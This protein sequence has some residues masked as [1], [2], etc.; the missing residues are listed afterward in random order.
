M[1]R[2][3]GHSAWR[4]KFKIIDLIQQLITH[5]VNISA[6][7][8]T[9]GCLSFTLVLGCRTP[10][11][12]RPETQTSKQSIGQNAFDLICSR[13]AYSERVP[14]QDGRKDVSGT[15]I[16]QSC[17]LGDTTQLGPSATYLVS[18]RDPIVIAI[19]ETIPAGLLPQIQHTFSQLIRSNAAGSMSTIMNTT[20]NVIDIVVQDDPLLSLLRQWSGR[21]GYAGTQSIWS[22][23]TAVGSYPFFNRLLQATTDF[24][25]TSD[26][27]DATR[28][29]ALLLSL[30]N[31][32]NA[33]ST[34]AA[35]QKPLARRIVDELI[36]PIS[37]AAT[38][39]ANT[40]DGATDHN[41]AT[42]RDGRGIALPNPST[43]TVSGPFRDDNADGLVDIDSYGRILSDQ[44]TDSILP[45]PFTPSRS[46]NEESSFTRD[47]QGR[48]KFN[49]QSVYHYVDLNP[50]LLTSL[51]SIARPLFDD[52]NNVV[53]DLMAGLDALLGEKRLYRTH[54]T[55]NGPVDLYY[56][57]VADSPIIDLIYAL[58]HSLD[59]PDVDS[60]IDLLSELLTKNSK[61]IENLL[62]QMISAINDISRSPNAPLDSGNMTNS[63]VHDH[64]GSI[65]SIFQE[66]SQV[67][68]FFEQVIPAFSQD[69]VQAFFRMWGVTFLY[70]DMHVLD[71]R[72]RAV[73][74]DDKQ[75]A[76]FKHR[77][78]ADR[79][80]ADRNS[81]SR[82]ILRY[83]DGLRGLT[84]CNKAN[85]KI[86]GFIGGFLGTFDECE[87]FE[88]I[89]AVQFFLQSLAYKRDDNGNLTDERLISLEVKDTA[90]LA[91]FAQNFIDIG[92]TED[93]A[94]Q[95]MTGIR[96]LSTNP[97]YS[98]LNRLMF[99][100]TM[101]PLLRTVID[102]IRDR[103]GDLVSE[104]HQG[105]LL[106]WEVEHNNITCPEKPCNTFRNF[107]PVV[108]A[109]ADFGLEDRLAEMF[110]RL[111]DS[112]ESVLPYEDAIGQQ[113]FDGHLMR[114][115]GDLVSALSRYRNSEG[116]SGIDIISKLARFFL[117]ERA[118]P[119]LTR[120]SGSRTFSYTYRGETF[121]S[122]IA[123]WHLYAD[124]IDRLSVSNI[125]Q[126]ISATLLTLFKE[127]N[128]Q[129]SLKNKTVLHVI[130]HVL[131]RAQ[132]ELRQEEADGATRVGSGIDN[133]QV[134]S[135]MTD[136]L[137][138]PII[139][140]LM[141]FTEPLASSESFLDEIANLARHIWDNHGYLNA[142]VYATFELL[143]G[144]E[145]QP[146]T[147]QSLSS[148][149]VLLQ[150]F[151]DIW[152]EIQSTLTA[153][154]TSEGGKET[155]AQL[156]YHLTAPTK[157]LQS[158]CPA[159]VL[160]DVTRSAARVEPSLQDPLTEVD[161]SNIFKTLRIILAD[162]KEGLSHL[163]DLLAQSLA[164]NT[165]DDSSLPIDD[166]SNENGPIQ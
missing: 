104:A 89:E 107:S 45:Q 62:G 153:I 110:V 34:K 148:L 25:A 92:D 105:S 72:L 97:S 69:A 67:D 13:V 157:T 60:L 10:D 91:P 3:Y 39:N 126:P 5:R 164:L 26:T 149:D 20:A 108:Q 142:V 162:P 32:A 132:D 42:R 66:L 7:G 35:T 47:N 122:N 50:S 29:P 51:F 117:D 11:L 27:T 40:S 127:N 83:I 154:T 87:L 138:S 158:K 58:L 68:G 80:P 99:Q 31:T 79:Q 90:S 136:L 100:D 53:P 129:F 18:V 23:F 151:A 48:L 139:P 116:L 71:W 4:S 102:P 30:S 77:I 156:L 88:S 155:I 78:P 135:D 64:L 37:Q 55:K 118:V 113:L 12:E 59:Y 1:A 114:S 131:Q 121:V 130:E 73:N 6:I 141:A 111:H 81:I 65:V 103:H 120:R 2:L 94:F 133:D 41:L 49:S 16:R 61:V 57:P 95:I 134:I 15:G 44:S 52:G 115:F 160:Y 165:V 75:P 161:L 33:V 28:V 19:D 119:G 74:E 22:L 82:R 152:P 144:L 70:E 96:G 84:I 143:Q 43:A 63:R 93:F 145:Q 125:L 101:S 56:Y 46:G 112:W 14:D 124:V 146:E 106:S 17:K 128:S 76:A 9:L 54:Q 86:G 8:Y 36:Q 150:S 147:R 85:A 163:W 159:E 21:R 166:A 140:A 24:L 98:S 123:L 38:R 137:Q 109:F